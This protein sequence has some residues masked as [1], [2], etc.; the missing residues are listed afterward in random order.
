MLLAVTKLPEQHI[1]EEKRCLGSVSEVV[2]PGHF[3]VLWLWHN[4]AEHQGRCDGHPV[5]EESCL[6]MATRMQSW[7]G[8]DWGPDIPFRAMA[9]VIHSFQISFVL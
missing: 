9:L 7:E 4:R 1:L 3:L 8:K 2:V 6:L 5:V